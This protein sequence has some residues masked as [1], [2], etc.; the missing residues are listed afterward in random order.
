MLVPEPSATIL[1]LLS[2]LVVLLRRKR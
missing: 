1:Q 2:A